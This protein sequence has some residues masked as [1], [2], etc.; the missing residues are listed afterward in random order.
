MNQ[1]INLY[2]QDFATDLQEIAVKLDLKEMYKYYD[3]LLL[4]QQRL[5]SQ[6]NKQLVFEEILIKWSKLNSR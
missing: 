2:N 1:E 5:E 4:S 6:I 3:F